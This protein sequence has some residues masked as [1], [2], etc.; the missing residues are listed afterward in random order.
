MA[1]LEASV[2]AAKASRENHPSRGRGASKDTTARSSKKK[3]AAKKSA[4]KKRAAKKS[5]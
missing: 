3:A 2:A 4:A 1:A 5:A